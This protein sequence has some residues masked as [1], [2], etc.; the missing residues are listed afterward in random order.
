MATVKYFDTDTGQWEYL[1]IGV[2]GDPGYGIPTG[3]LENEILIKGSDTDYDFI[4]ASPSDI[5]KNFVQN[6]TVTDIVIVEHNL[7]KYPS[8]SVI[9]SAGDEVEGDIFYNSV[10][11]L[12]VQFA[13]TFSGKIICN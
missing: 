1:A 10:S 9:D 8:V 7:N 3:G 12:T 5:D 13:N 4:W 6:F 2:K 11:Q